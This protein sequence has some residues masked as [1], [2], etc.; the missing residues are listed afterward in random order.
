MDIYHAQN[1]IL[2]CLRANIDQ[3]HGTLLDI[4]C[5]KMPYKPLIL[6]APSRV[7]KYIGMDFLDGAYGK[8]DLGWDGKHIPLDTNTIDCSLAT[9]LFEHCSD[10]E[11]VMREVVRVL[12]PGCL[13]YF[14][15]PFFWPLHCLPN[16]EYR[17]TH[18]ALERHLRRAGFAE[19]KM[20][21]WGGWDASLAQMLGLWVRR[22]SIRS[23]TRKI[24]SVLTLPVVRLLLKRDK[25]CDDFPN[26]AMITGISGIATTPSG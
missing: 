11:N 21:T 7:K 22:S 25:A 14:S 4:G 3:F 15:V 1:A 16:D 18:I 12:R 23:S 19:V 9:E 10:P 8:P 24:L 2:K 26:G 17:Y 13:L 5:G 6:A 20:R